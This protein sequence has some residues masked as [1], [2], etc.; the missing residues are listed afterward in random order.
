MPS[1]SPKKKEKLESKFDKWAYNGPKILPSNKHSEVGVPKKK[2]EDVIDLDSA[3]D[4]GGAEDTKK[5]S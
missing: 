5:K 4:G 1:K 2:K 3:S